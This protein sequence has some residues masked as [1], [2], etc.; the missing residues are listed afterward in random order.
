M[1]SNIDTEVIVQSPP[2]SVQSACCAG[3]TIRHVAKL[4]TFGLFTSQNMKAVV[5]V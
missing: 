3:V 2:V 4:T 1:T 5:P